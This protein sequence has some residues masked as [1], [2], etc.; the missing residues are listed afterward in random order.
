MILR[1][2]SMSVLNLMAIRPLDQTTNV[3][4]A[5]VV[6]VNSGH[7]NECLYQNILVDFGVFHW[8]GKDRESPKPVGFIFRGH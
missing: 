1:E 8:I 4:L 6:A 2:A 7:H 5:V 3:K